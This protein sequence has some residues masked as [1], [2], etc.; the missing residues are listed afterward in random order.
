MLL[1]PGDTPIEKSDEFVVCVEGA[2]AGTS[3]FA[4]GDPNPVTK[5]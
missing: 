1:D 4:I 3:A 2:R 5:S